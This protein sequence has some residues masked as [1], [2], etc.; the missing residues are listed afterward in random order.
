M[1]DIKQT[2]GKL[3]LNDK[4]IDIYLALLKSGPASVQN[5]SRSTSISRSTVYQRLE[6]L[7]NAGLVNFEFGEKGKAVKAIHP[8]KLKEI[9][10]KKVMESR[11][12]SNDYN[13]ILPELSNLY[14]PVSTKSK[15]MYFEGLSGLK[16]MIMNYEMEAKNK[17]LYGFSAYKEFKFIKLIFIK[18]I[19]RVC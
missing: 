15:V 5:V 13:A 18:F 4:E 17:D 3:N 14:Q 8:E 16:R 7:K 9:I 2:L 10:D 11:K 1:S 6:N 19:N 12:L